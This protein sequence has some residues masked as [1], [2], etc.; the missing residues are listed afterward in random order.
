LASLCATAV[1]AAAAAAGPI[2]YL[3]GH[4][5]WYIAEV[6]LTSPNIR[7]EAAVANNGA[8][9][10]QTVPAIAA[11]RGADLGIVADYSCGA[12][13]DNTC[14][15][16]V[17]CI[18][19][20]N[21]NGS[22]ACAESLIWVN[23]VER[24]NFG[25]VQAP[26]YRSAI[27]FNTANR[28]LIAL[29]SEMPG[30]Y[31]HNLVSAGPWWLR[32]GQWRWDPVNQ[33]SQVTFNGPPTEIFGSSAANWNNARPLSTI[34]YNAD[35]TKM[36]F[37]TSYVN[38]TPEEMRQKLAEL[39]AHNAIR[40]DSG[41]SA[42]FY[43][44]SKVDGTAGISYGSR[45]L[46]NALLVFITGTG[47]GNCS[48]SDGAVFVSETIPDG[49][50]IQ[51]GSVFTKTW[52]LRNSGSS[53]WRK[54]CNHKFA[55]D[56]GERF[57][58]PEYT[59][60]G[61]S[62]AIAP[63][64]NKTWSLTMTAPTTT[65]RYRG[66]WRM[67][68]YG[69]GRFGHRV[70][71]DI[72]VVGTP[73]PCSGTDAAQYVSESAP[74][75]GAT[76]QAGQTFT[77][78]WTLRNTGT[79]T[80]RNSCNHKFAFDGGERFG[81]PEYTDVGGDVAPGQTKT[82]TLNM[83][84][85]STPG[86]YRG[87][88]K[89]DRYGTG[90]FGDRVWVEVNVVASQP[91]GGTDNALFLSESAPYDGATVQA[92]QTFTK[93][94]TLRNTG[95]ATWRNSCNH[96]FA[97]DGGE[98]FGAP[99]Y[100]DVGSDVAPGQTKTFTLT[101][102][103]PITSGLV[104]GYW[105]MDRYGTGRF[106]D[107]V[108]V[109][110]NVQNPCPSG[111]ENAAFVSESGPPDGTT[112][113]QGQV[114]VKSW[115]L[116]NT[117]TTT[118]RKSCGYR[119]AWVSG[120]FGTPA[121]Y[122]LGDAEA[123]APGQ[124]KTWTLN[125][126]VPASNG[127]V[128]GTWRME[129]SG[130]RFGDAVW[131]ELNV[132]APCGGGTNHAV[133]VGEEPPLDGDEIAAGAAFTKR[134]TIRNA[135]SSVW[136]KNCGY[137][138]AFV[139]GNSF[140]APSRID[141]GDA[142]RIAPGET[143]TWAV[144]MTAP[145]TAGTYRSVWQMERAGAGQFGQPV[146]VEL[147]VI[148]PCSGGRDGATAVGESPP[149]DGETVTTNQSFVKTWRLRNTGD[150]T[151]TYE[152]GYQLVFTGGHQFGGPATIDL[153]SYI[154]SN[155]V[156]WQTVPPGA[157][158]AWSVA[159][160]AP[161]T[162]GRYRG[163]WR[164]AKR[165]R[166]FGDPV[167]IDVHVAG[168]C[169]EGVNG[170][171][172]ANESPPYDGD[173]VSINAP[174]V[175]SWTLR[176]SGATTWT[177]AC[178]YRFAFDGGARMGGPAFVELEPGETVA[179]GQSRTWTVNLT[180][181]STS[182]THR[183]YWRM[184]R[185]GVRFGDRV[186]VEIVASAS[187]LV[188]DGFDYPL[189]PRDGS[190]SRPPDYADYNANNPYLTQH[191]ACYGVPLS[192]CQHAG[193]DW[194]APPGSPVYAVANGRVALSRFANYPGYVVVIEHTLPEGVLSPWSNRTICSMYGHLSATDLIPEG[195]H[196]VRGQ[197][198]GRLYDWG[199]NTHLHFEM[200]RWAN[201][202]S[203]PASVGGCTFCRSWHGP[204]YTAPGCHP[205]LFGYTEPQAWIAANRPTC[206]PDAYETNDTLA[207]AYSLPAGTRVRLSEV[208][209]PAR[210]GNDDWYRIDVPRPWMRIA[211]T[212]EFSHAA[213]DIDLALHNPN[214]ARVAASEGLTDREV[215]T[216]DAPTAGPHYLRLFY[217][218]ACNVYDLV[219]HL[220]ALDSDGDG[221][222]DWWEERHFGG[223]TNAIATADADDDG[224]TAVEEFWAGTDPTNRASLL[225]LRM[226][227]ADVESFGIRVEWPSAT[228]RQYHLLR[229]TNLLAPYLPLATNMPATPPLNVHTDLQSI[230]SAFY[231]IQAEPIPG[232]ESPE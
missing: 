1:L 177:R 64:Q 144:D 178:G 176:N 36:W 16:S 5:G 206:P 190:G 141:L 226:P 216:Y 130:V 140:G 218:N 109:E 139:S 54:S 232:L 7:V 83:T 115:T 220:V 47:G 207:T 146:W 188:T 186:W 126:T 80:W 136:T 8:G 117:G 191:S 151:W 199:S 219:V 61:D 111:T 200:R 173:A 223:R 68:R 9:G 35:R 153:P 143:K 163:A 118:W 18:K 103:A 58:A 121:Y 45:P 170:A 74:Y 147:N 65:G 113:T 210:Q 67:D 224:M 166:F 52:T 93:S 100:T 57:G 49:T 77:K 194:F 161:S 195:A 32:D 51:A 229:A 22:R 38:K 184:E 160:T 17:C 209:G 154:V 142:E 104:R 127:L 162:P 214:G 50:S 24:S 31:K 156:M 23:G 180:A 131:T 231:L 174:F 201:M 123:I 114:V 171:Q 222:P 217:G 213:G 211:A 157:T 19:A 73:N 167:W 183:G 225:R 202:N 69:T 4:S 94:W 98:R 204:G 26:Q 227:Q 62:E 228:G 56:G 122:E 125:L 14:P 169:G 99:E 84:A 106:G 20:Y 172:F 182:G 230:G 91:C 212:A 63:G 41:G 101:M 148:D 95:T 189:D 116:R 179:P 10:Y 208:A 90:R 44:S 79:A 120:A 192:R 27:G 60:L 33:G 129:R 181:P 85:P 221:L 55:F 6:D 40:C 196:V 71:V 150:T 107:R 149:F 135:G 87:Y 81:A 193:E 108:W 12:G 102:T 128:R 59:E 165:G 72:N 28:P 124:V 78:S 34:A 21:A 159:L 89:M 132:V 30:E 197:R 75:D 76:V 82:F 29:G 185:N 187:N 110:V 152:C 37:I 48:G 3:S 158:Q 88:W 42:S 134:W 96:K 92:G 53:T 86:L 145:A 168:A 97:F 215:V 138:L 205:D 11:A 25:W 119:F 175:K 164:M 46:P 66:Y 15:G 198:I 39:G 133:F 112:V 137:R 203:A 2:R 70:W 105:K 155:T 43:A 13:C